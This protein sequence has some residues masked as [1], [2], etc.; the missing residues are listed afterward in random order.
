MIAAAPSRGRK[1]RGSGQ[2][3]FIKPSAFT[4]AWW[5]T[6]LSCSNRLPQS[7]GPTAIGKASVIGGQTVVGEV[8]MVDKATTLDDDG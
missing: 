6:L 8:T 5:V 7:A 1:R 2:F 4:K 3:K